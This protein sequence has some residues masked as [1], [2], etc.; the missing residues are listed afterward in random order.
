MVLGDFYSWQR[1]H[2]GIPEEYKVTS[3]IPCRDLITT[4]GSVVDLE[5]ISLP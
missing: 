5:Q 3:K 4:D 2:W 1:N